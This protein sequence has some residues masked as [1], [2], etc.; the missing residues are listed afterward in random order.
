MKAPPITTQP[1][2]PSE[3][4]AVDCFGDRRPEGSGYDTGL[5]EWTVATNG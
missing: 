5:D 1:E 4:G 3:A 2:G